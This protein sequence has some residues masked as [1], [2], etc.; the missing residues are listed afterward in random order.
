MSLQHIPREG[1]IMA[2]DKDFY[3]MTVEEVLHVLET[4]KDG[5]PRDEAKKRLERYGR[6]ELSVEAKISAWLMFLLCSY[7]N[8]KTYW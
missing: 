2:Q 7:P 3:N 4:S 8:L 5:L 6:N 1:F